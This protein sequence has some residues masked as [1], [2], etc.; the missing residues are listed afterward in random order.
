MVERKDES[1]EKEAEE[2]I[3]PVEDL[4]REHGVL[5]RILL[6]YEDSI[7]KLSTGKEFSVKTLSDAAGIIQHFIQ[8]YHEKLEEYYL[9]PQFRKAGMMVDLVTTLHQQPEAGH[10]L[11]ADILHLLTNQNLKNVEDR[12]KLIDCLNQFIRMYRPH[13]AWGG[14]S[15]IPSST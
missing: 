8:D 4:M 14:H 3:S 9:F 7:K 10:R 11:T 13:A 2:K 12:K 6:I 5:N 1:S 15:A